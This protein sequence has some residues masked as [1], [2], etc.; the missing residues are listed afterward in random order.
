LIDDVG[1]GL[2][3]VMVPLVLAVV[4]AGLPVENGLPDGDVTVLVFVVVRALAGFDV[5]GMVVPF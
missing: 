4:F 3:V 5:G 1:V 2:P